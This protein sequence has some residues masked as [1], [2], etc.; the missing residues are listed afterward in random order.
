MSSKVILCFTVI[1][2]IISST[3]AREKITP[4]RQKS[5]IE[6][7][8]KLQNKQYLKY[9]GY[10]ISLVEETSEYNSKTGK[11]LKKNKV[12]MTKKIPL[13]GKATI[14]NVKKYII[15][16]TR[17]PIDEFKPRD[18]TVFYN[19][20]DKNGHRYY[21]IRIK[22]LKKIN[23]T[24]CYA[25]NIIPLNNTKKHL[26]ATLYYSKKYLRLLEMDATPAKLDFG[27]KKICIKVK[28]KP[29]NDIDL[30]VKTYVRVFVDV[31]L[32]YPNRKLIITSSA[33]EHNLINN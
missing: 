18:E 3:F 28:F 11:L 16:G 25:V 14:L 5:I 6:K 24:L 10:K 27:V 15:N 2:I 7:I 32:F 30:P 19:A 33:L 1:L 26:R 21:K 12:E 20:F 13:Y 17:K 22:G 9:W 8:R 29:F 31:F 4:E 23:N